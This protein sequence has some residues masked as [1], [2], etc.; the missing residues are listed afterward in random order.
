MLPCK[1]DSWAREF[2][3]LIRK[4]NK[5]SS[6]PP[7]EERCLCVDFTVRNYSLC[8]RDPFIEPTSPGELEMGW[9]WQVA[10][11]GCNSHLLS[12]SR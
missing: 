8:L 11:F 1:V 10:D 7:R 4:G 9:G 2:G 12:S 5:L 6:C 3:R